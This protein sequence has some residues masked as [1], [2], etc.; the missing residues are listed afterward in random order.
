ME[1]FLAFM[2]A[3]TE[4]LGVGIANWLLAMIGSIGLWAIILLREW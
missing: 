2:L 1:A 4:I 3:E